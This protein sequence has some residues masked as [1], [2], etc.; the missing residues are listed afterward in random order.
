MRNSSISIV[1]KYQ[2]I[3]YAS[4][5]EEEIYSEVKEQKSDINKTETRSGKTW[6]QKKKNNVNFTRPPEQSST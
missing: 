5:I 2:R 4:G 3:D 6:K 1:F